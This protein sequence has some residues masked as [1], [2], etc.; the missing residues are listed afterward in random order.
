MRLFAQRDCA[1]GQAQ[2]E[3]ATQSADRPGAWYPDP[4]GTAQMRWW[5]GKG[6]TQQTR[7]AS[8]ASTASSSADV[9]DPRPEA[10][11]AQVPPR[12]RESAVAQPGPAEARQ[13]IVTQRSSRA[14]L[15][16]PRL[17]ALLLGGLVA[18]ALVITSE[19]H[20]HAAPQVHSVVAATGTHTGARVGPA[21]PGATTRQATGAGTTGRPLAGSTH[22]R[23]SRGATGH[24]K[25]HRH[26]VRIRR[27]QRLVK[28]AFDIAIFFDAMQRSGGKVAGTTT[29]CIPAAGT[30]ATNAAATT[31]NCTAF[32]HANSSDSGSRYRYTGTVD[33]DSGQVT[34]H[35]AGAE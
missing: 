15:A 26:R 10:P 27:R 7:A 21:H 3:A 9:T 5:D 4:F 35:F 33:V 13:A 28:R 23:T 1:T 11:N 16:A 6:W 30:T 31:F 8:V 29:T 20:G 25:S 24:R 2:D 12:H 32:V 34:W 22:Q 19:H 17:I 18:A 14:K